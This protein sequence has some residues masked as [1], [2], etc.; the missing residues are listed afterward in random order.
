MSKILFPTD[1]SLA[2]RNALDYAIALAKKMQE[3]ITLFHV[4]NLGASDRRLSPQELQKTIVE[5]EATIL[6]RFEELLEHITADAN[7]RF[8]KVLERGQLARRIT[9]FIN[10]ANKEE[11]KEREHFEW[12]VI[13]STKPAGFRDFL[14]GSNVEEIINSTHIPVLVIP[15][16]Q[17]AFKGIRKIAYATNLMDDNIIALQKLDDFAKLFKAELVFVHIDED[18]TEADRMLF[19]KYERAL[20]K[21]IESSFTIKLIEDN[22]V[23]ESLAS[24]AHNT[25]VDLLAM[26]R[27]R[28]SFTDKMFYNSVTAKMLA[29][30]SLPILVLQEETTSQG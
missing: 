18:I 25:D 8:D 3:N 28:K 17:Q 10:H 19:R 13:S 11:K 14:F 16:E 12:L 20:E 7:M 23:T 26:F 29:K 2:S 21:L 27:K 6:P 4:Y 24:Y 1:F 30:N 22:N 15:E 5:H 9:S